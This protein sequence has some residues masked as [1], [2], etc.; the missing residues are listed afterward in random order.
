MDE[1][2]P[3]GEQC[4]QVVD[5]E[6]DERVVG[7]EAFDQVPQKTGAAPILTEVNEVPIILT[8]VEEALEEARDDVRAELSEVADRIAAG[9]GRRRRVGQMR[10]M[11]LTSRA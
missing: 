5:V 4:P 8:G 7:V 2:A 6:V 9:C 11:R 3:G 10:S 1:S